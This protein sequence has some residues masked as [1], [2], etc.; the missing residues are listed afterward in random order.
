VTLTVRAIEVRDI[1]LVT[2]DYYKVTDDAGEIWVRTVRGL[3]LRGLRYRVSGSLVPSNG[4]VEGLLGGE[5]ILK[6]AA[7]EEVDP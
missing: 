7:R 6:E 5:H 1:P 4:V 2:K 3:P